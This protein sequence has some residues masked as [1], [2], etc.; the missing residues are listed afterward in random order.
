M[1]THKTTKLDK[2]T[3]SK[4]IAVKNNFPIQISADEREKI[5]SLLKHEV[6]LEELYDVFDVILAP[7]IRSIKEL[8]KNWLVTQALLDGLGVDKE[9]FDK[10]VK[11]VEEANRK[12]YEDLKKQMEQADK[13]VQ[14]D[15][16]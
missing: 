13:K 9:T 5:Q 7:Y 12:A 4:G 8:E 3:V 1:A 15:K 6:S 2:D 11:E 10:A 16:D 14:N